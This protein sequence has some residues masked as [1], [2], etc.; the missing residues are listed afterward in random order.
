M[1]FS[2]YFELKTFLNGLLL[3]EDKL[4][5]AHGVESRVPFLDNDLVDFA[6]KI[7]LRYKLRNFQAPER[8]DENVIGRKSERYFRRTNDGKL[9]LRKVFELCTGIVRLGT[10]AGFFG[11]RR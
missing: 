2:L 3:V 6:M 1:N 5:M 11:A 4:H 9:I 7:P 10:Q 8:I